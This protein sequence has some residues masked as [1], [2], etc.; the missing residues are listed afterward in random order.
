MGVL[1]APRAPISCFDNIRENNFLSYIFNLNVSVRAQAVYQIA[2]RYY[3]RRRR[4]RLRSRDDRTARGSVYNF[5]TPA[6]GLGF[7]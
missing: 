7:E 2:P 1:T 3:R 6:I 5:A 4:R